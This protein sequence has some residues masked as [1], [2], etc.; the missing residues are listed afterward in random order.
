M[1]CQDSHWETALNAMGPIAV[2]HAL[3]HRLLKEGPGRFA[4]DWLVQLHE[5]EQQASDAQK[6]LDA[7]LLEERRMTIQM[8]QTML[9]AIAA[10]A[11]ILVFVFGPGVLS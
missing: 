2:R 8:F 5:A 1:R 6:A 7:R 4:A 10:I 9:A 11:A 3:K